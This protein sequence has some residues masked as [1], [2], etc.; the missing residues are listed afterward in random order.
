MKRREALVSEVILLHVVDT[1]L[2]YVMHICR[3]CSSL[4]ISRS[5]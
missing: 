3:K 5:V 1:I 2:L 4:T